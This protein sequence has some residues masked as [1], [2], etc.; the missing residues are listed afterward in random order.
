MLDALKSELRLSGKLN[1]FYAAFIFG[2]Y[3]FGLLLAALILKLGEEVTYFPMG[4]IMAMMGAVMAEVIYDGM[5]FSTDFSLAASMGRRR[6]PKIAAHG[7]TALL[8]MV[9]GT[10]VIYLLIRLDALIGR[11]F[12]S[13][14]EVELDLL[15][16]ISFGAAA[17]FAVVPVVISLLVSAV[18]VRFGMRGWVTL[19]VIFMA[20]CLLLPRLIETV[21]ENPELPLSKAAAA[22]VSAIASVITPAL[23]IGIALLAA[24]VILFAAFRMMMRA[25]INID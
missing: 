9:I 15:P 4:S 23:G 24:A 16:Y 22:A 11:S 21:I 8:R 10:G 19:Y 7:I 13:S 14:L 12:Y 17:A 1:G 3:A 18:K 20:C 2:A 5:R 25:Q 6:L